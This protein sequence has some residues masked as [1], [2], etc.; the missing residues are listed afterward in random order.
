MRHTLAREGTRMK[1]RLFT[2]LSALSLLLFV[3]VV[4]LWVRS[5]SHSDAVGRARLDG[6]H[7]EARSGRGYLVLTAVRP[8]PFDLPLSWSSWRL[9]EREPAMSMGVTASDGSLWA[10]PAYGADGKLLALGGPMNPS[11]IVPWWKVQA[12]VTLAAGAALALRIGYG[13]RLARWRRQRRCVICG[14][15]LRA[16]PERCPECGKVITHR[17]PR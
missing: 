10:R 11:A 7:V 1:R 3:A 5:Y 12:A 15:D 4:V 14:Y 17:S 6:W 2:I 16:T 9:E 8:C 13:L